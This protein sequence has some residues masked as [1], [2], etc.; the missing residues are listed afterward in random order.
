MIK[1]IMYLASVLTS[2]KGFDTIQRNKILNKLHHHGIR[3]IA[4]EI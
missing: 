3:R 4:F 1:D 2:K